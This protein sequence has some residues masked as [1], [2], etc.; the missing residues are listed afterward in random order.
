M[1]HTVGNHFL[2]AK[3]LLFLIPR[4]NT[5]Y[6]SSIFAVY[7]PFTTPAIGLCLPFCSTANRKYLG[8]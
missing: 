3:S 8:R 7:L 6:G 2:T 5:T 1:A 4:M